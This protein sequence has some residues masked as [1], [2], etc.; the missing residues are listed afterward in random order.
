MLNFESLDTLVCK[1]KMTPCAKKNDTC[2]KKMS[3]VAKKND[4]R[5]KKKTPL[6]LNK[7][8]VFLFE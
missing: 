3:P 6:E 7:F 8:I 5:C 2:C 1:K 4:T